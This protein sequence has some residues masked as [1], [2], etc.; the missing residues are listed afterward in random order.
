VRGKYLVFGAL[1]GSLFLGLGLA[2]TRVFVQR[3]VSAKT[4]IKSVEGINSLEKLELGGAEQWILIRGWDRKKPLL[5]FL[6]GGPGFPEMP[7]A[8]LNAELEK[9]FV[10]IH[11]D[12]RGAGK[13][14][15][16]S[17]D[18]LD[19]EQF[20]GDACEL[21]SLLL[22][23]FRAPKL[24]LVGHSWGSLVGALTAAR[25]PDKLFAYIGISQ[26]ADAPESERMM[27]RFA[28]EQAQQT[29]NKKATRQL[30]G[31]GQPPYQSMRDFRTMKNWVG[32]FGERDHPMMSRWRFARFALAS[33]VYSWR[34]LLNLGLGA[35]TSFEELWREV[36]YKVNLF[37][38][39]P[40]LNVPVYFLEGRHDRV[41][42]V[43]SAM[44][45]RYFNSLD[46]PRGKQLIW[47]DNS[48]H[49]PQLEEPEKFRRVL[50]KQV[51][52]AA[53]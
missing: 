15:P 1:T 48:G 22:R 39:A 2:V 16:V 4:A 26:F 27:Y 10:V 34:D 18:S 37:R 24:L 35:R 33:P 13:S 36:F 25:E 12:Q 32:T 52:S 19:V 43:S 21:T 49:W 38:D 41:V 53:R 29:W 31:I 7:F 23:R 9:E 28:L 20:V 42:T 17:H 44:A 6:H 11:W 50:V 47:F 3:A 51:L 45:E 30:T 5:L 14:Y 46:A 8:H 40:R